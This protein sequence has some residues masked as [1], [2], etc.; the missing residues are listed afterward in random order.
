M[1]Q[2]P[3]LCACNVC[4]RVVRMPCDGNCAYHSI[5]FSLGGGWNARQLRALVLANVTSTDARL[6]G[7]T[8]PQF[9][10]AIR[11]GR[12][13]DNE[14]LFVLTAV[15][16]IRIVIIDDDRWEIYQLGRVG[17]VV[18]MVRVNEAH[19]NACTMDDEGKSR[20]RRLCGTRICTP[21]RHPKRLYRLCLHAAA[22]IVLFFVFAIHRERIAQK[23]GSTKS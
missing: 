18:Y 8:L 2:S 22:I 17:L 12:W 19:Y 3:V 1:R 14:E 23:L 5:A 10:H 7:L 4:H 15:L 9:R 16:H 21:I 13:A 11:R 20:V 6:N